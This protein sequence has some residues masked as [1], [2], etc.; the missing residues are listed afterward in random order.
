[1]NKFNLVVQSVCFVA[2]AFLYAK[3][4]TVSVVC[5]LVFCAVNFG[6]AL[7]LLLPRP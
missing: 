1:M 2:S 3:H 4:P 6:V 7:G 5:A